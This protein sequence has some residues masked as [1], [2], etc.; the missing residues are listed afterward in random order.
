VTKNDYYALRSRPTL[1]D[2]LLLLSG[3]GV[4]LYL[5]R[6]GPL[7]VEPGEHVTSPVL[8]EVV[9]SFLPT[10]MRLPEGVLLLGPIFFLLQLI[11]GRR[12]GPTGAEWLWALAWLGTALLTGLSAWARTDTVPELLQP[13]VHK[14]LLLWYLI[15]VPAMAALALVLA[16]LG[17]ASSTP[18]PWTHSLGLALVLWPALP[19]GAIFTLGNF[20]TERKSVPRMTTTVLGLDVGGANLKAAHTDGA[21]RSRPF[22]LWK[23]P[24]GLPAAV[25]ALIA[26]MPRAD[27]LAVTMT[28]ELCD[29]FETKREGVA[30]IL[31]AV[32]RAAGGLPVRVWRNDG[33]FVDLKAARAT[34]LKVAAANWLALA[35]FAGRFAQK[36]PALLLDIG[37]TT[38]DV[39][40]LRDGRPAPQGRT[41][42]ERLRC[43]ELVYTGARRTP[44]CAILGAEGPA[45][46][47]A[48]TLDV[49]LLLGWVAEDATDRNTADGRPATKAAAEARLAR[50]L[51]ADLETSTAKKREKL[52]QRVL[53]KQIYTLKWAVERVARRL[54]QP[55]RTVIVAGEGEFLSR[56]LL[57]QQE[58]IPPCDVVFLG[59]N[60][61]PEVSR[62]ACAYAVAVLAAETEG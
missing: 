28:G 12:Q 17:L 10:V 3:C 49:Y 14:P 35:T 52:A 25:S 1:V 22:A 58:A 6:L 51:G 46:F 19:L 41:D 43:E 4:S 53:L 33:R 47:F 26:E 13:Y 29:C 5:V 15:F 37:S 24:A 11:L 16:V 34:P 55:P 2:Y 38:T 56:P 30:A 21:A 18:K 20:T 61:S 7:W 50:M 36:G 44:L 31:D 60:I 9:A 62:A 59:N 32:E 27:R 42:P 54:P 57:E 39:V 45:E 40:P 8:S 23:D 48:T